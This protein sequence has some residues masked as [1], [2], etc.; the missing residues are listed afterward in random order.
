MKAYEQFTVEASSVNIMEVM[1]Q[2][3]APTVG[4]STVCVD[5]RWSFWRREGFMR[6]FN[7]L[8]MNHFF[9]PRIN[10]IVRSGT[11]IQRVPGDGESLQ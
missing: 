9:R 7:N 11:G 6:L 2:S 10:G 4:F 8:F 3:T 1:D 5:I